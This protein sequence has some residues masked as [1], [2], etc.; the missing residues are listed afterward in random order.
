LFAQHTL[1]DPKHSFLQSG[2]MPGRAGLFC[3]DNKSRYLNIAYLM[4]GLA[5]NKAMNLEKDLTG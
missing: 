4:H 5:G 2:A 1:F 3:T